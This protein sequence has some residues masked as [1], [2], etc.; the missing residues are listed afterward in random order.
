MGPLELATLIGLFLL[1]FGYRFLPRLGRNLGQ[2]T[3]ELER[4]DER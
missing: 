2:A 4:G 1:L 3:G